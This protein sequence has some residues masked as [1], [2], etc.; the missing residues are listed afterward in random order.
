M[1]E[2]ETLARSERAENSQSMSSQLW[3]T[4]LKERGSK[5]H[6]SLWKKLIPGPVTIG[7]MVLLL[8]ATGIRVID[9]PW[10]EIFRVKTFDLYQI[11][12]PR[13]PITTK[14]GVAIVDIDERSLSAVGQ[15][16]WSRTTIGDLILQIGKAGGL[17]V[18]FDMFFPEYDRTSP[19]VIANTIRGIDAGTVK[20]L[21]SLP[22][23]EDAMV[24]AMKQVRVVVGQVGQSNELPAGQL[25]PSNKTSVKGALG[26]NPMPFL[27]KYQSMLG[28]VPEIEANASGHGFVSLVDEIDGI[29]RRVPMIA[30]VG[31]ENM[32]R[33]GLTIEMLRA[34]FGGNG[35]ITKRNVAGMISLILQ[36]PGGQRFEIP[37]DAQGR[38]FV[39]YAKPD[40]YNTPD[41]SG[42]LY[43]SAGDVLNGSIGPNKLKD[44]LVVVGISA[45]G[46]QDIRATPIEPRMPGVEVHANILETIIAANTLEANAK[47]LILAQFKVAAEAEGQTPT[48][49]EV[50]TAAQPQLAKIKQSQ[51]YLRYPN[52]SNAAEIT[53][54]ILAGIAMMIFVPR[55]GPI[56]ALAGLVTATTGLSWLGWYLYIDKLVLVDVTYPGAVTFI[57]YA[58][59][60][61]SNYMREATEKKK[62]RGA[63]GMYL[64]PDLVNQLAENPSQ[65]KL[66]GE[67]KKMTFLF[68]DVRGFTSIS[69]TFKANPMG[70][71]QLVNRLLTPLTEA[72]LSRN[73]TIDKYMGDCIM[74]FWN[75]PLDDKLHSE[76]AC[77]SALAMFKDLELLNLTREKEAKE[78]GENFL[79]LN[80]G[81]GINTG[82]CVVGNMGSEQRFD[83]S[84]LGDAVNLAA[85]LEGQSKNYGVKIVIGEDTARQVDGK[86]AILPLD[87]IAVKGKTVA[88]SIFTILG[89]SAYVVTPEFK[90]L[91]DVHTSMIEAYLTQDWDKSEQFIKECRTFDN[92]QM[93][94]FYDIYEERLASYRKNP[95]GSDWDG[96]LIATTK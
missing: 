8:V 80:V 32:P 93:S 28:N 4:L 30:M 92:G 61:F 86:F 75:A 37:T 10:V 9:P 27:F 29:V 35:I 55:V 38:V 47:Q 33:P 59:L 16:P 43:V 84:V 19:P 69:E 11:I 95:P 44:K 3:A 39:H 23:N 34:A 53:I 87:M 40:K 15:W 66:G 48:H 90:K 18:G 82:D 64:S 79:P 74:A 63:F 20:L 85:R 91:Y 73:G 77:T 58:V 65:L 1:A 2:T 12:K 6:V 5:R 60:I 70:L 14:I 54:M 13:E 36:L 71:T 50:I 46:L 96:V 72:I 83:Y 52:F 17:V 81:I 57:I 51:F 62:V 24:K 25:P 88:V 42:R 89:D 49:H 45:A 67:T 22:P 21:K 76:H 41:N 78:M 31:E 94:E 56:W 7:V 68:C 26:G